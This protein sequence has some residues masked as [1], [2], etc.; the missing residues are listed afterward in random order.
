MILLFVAAGCLTFNSCDSDD[1]DDNT[2]LSDSL[3][4]A[5][6]LT[7]AILPNAQDF[8]NDGDDSTNA[9]LEGPCYNDSW[10]SF[11]EDGT[12]DESWSMSTVVSGAITMGCDSQTSSGTYSVSG[13]TVTTMASGSGQSKTFTFNSDNRTVVMTQ[14]DMDYPAWN[15]ITS[16]WSTLQADINLTFT[17]YTDDDQDNGEN[18]DN[19]GEND[20]ENNANFWLL[21]NFNLTSM[22]VPTAQNLDNDGD[23]SNNLVSEST[24]YG[25]SYLRFNADGTYQEERVVPVISDNFLSLSCQTQTTFGT[26]MRNGNIITTTRTSS[27]SGSATTTYNFNATTHLLTRTDNSGSF[28]SFSSGTS[29]Y[30]MLD[31]AVNYTYTR[32]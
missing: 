28:P 26:W 32:N 22:M 23:N 12:Y 24:C 6:R 25:Q 7:S 5:Y 16:L 13:N 31:G 29:L 4:G 15:T 2:T 19:D 9:V 20:D 10:I 1:D 3:V 17:K 8:D 27:G 18:A 30:S 14:N 11:H 21:G